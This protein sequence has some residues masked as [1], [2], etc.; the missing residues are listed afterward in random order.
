[1]A[2]GAGRSVL[3]GALEAE[4][5]DPK[6]RL[7]NGALLFDAKGDLRGRYRKSIL[8]PFGE[9]DPLGGLWPAFDRFVLELTDAIRLD[10]GEGS[11]LLRTWDSGGVAH[12]FGLLVCYEATSG[13]YARRYSGLGAEFLVNITSDRWTSDPGAMRQHAAFSVFRAVEN[14]KSLFRV[15]NGGLSCAI[16]PLGRVI[17][18]LP[19][20]TYGTIS[21]EPS[22]MEGGPTLYARASDWILVFA[23]LVT[24]GGAA[25]VLIRK[26]VRGK[27]H[28]VSGEDKRHV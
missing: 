14:R 12:A 15:G 4:K 7:Y 28:P 23:G 27:V 22:L 26:R 2:R 25:P 24:L 19:L 3:I 1:M 21:W 13:D 10:S 11:R 6:P 9:A 20:F 17:T 5:A 16:D 18:E 8:A